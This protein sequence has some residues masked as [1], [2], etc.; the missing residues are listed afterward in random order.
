ME[1]KFK[2]LTFNSEKEFNEW[3]DKTTFVK[4]F[5][6]QK[7]QDLTKLW[8]ADSGEVLHANMQ[9]KIWNGKFVNMKTLKQNTNL[10]FFNENTNEWDVM[11]FEV[12]AIRYNNA[13]QNQ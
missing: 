4:V 8:L 11:N 6:N 5:L 2:K 3:L 13:T 9:A 12:G 1:A 7:G 10:C